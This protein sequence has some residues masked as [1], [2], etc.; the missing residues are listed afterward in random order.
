MTEPTDSTGHYTGQP[1][2]TTGGERQDKFIV[3]RPTWCTLRTANLME[4]VR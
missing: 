1:Q 4:G 2:A 3:P